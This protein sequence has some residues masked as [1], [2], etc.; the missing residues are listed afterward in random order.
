VYALW[1]DGVD[2]C[3]RVSVRGKTSSHTF[4]LIFQEAVAQIGATRVNHDSGMATVKRI[5]MA[6]D[7]VA[8]CEIGSEKQ[9]ESKQEAKQEAKQESKSRRK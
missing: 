7:M 3:I 1:C 5:R 6:F 2:G 9:R 8:E 4:F